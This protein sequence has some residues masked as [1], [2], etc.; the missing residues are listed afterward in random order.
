MP[1]GDILVF[2]TGQEEIESLTLL[3]QDKL[4]LLPPNASSLLVLALSLSHVGVSAL[5]RAS[6]GAAAGCVHASATQHAQGDSLDESRRIFRDHSRN[7]IRR[8]HG[9]GEAPCDAGGDGTRVAARGA[10]FQIA[11]VAA[12]GSCRSRERG[13]GSCIQLFARSAS[14]SS[15]KT[16]SCRFEKTPFPRSSAAISPASFFR[17]LHLSPLPQ[18]KTIGINDVLNFNYL[19]APSRDSLKRALQQ[20]LMLGAVDRRSVV[21]R[22]SHDTGRAD[23]AG[24][25][26]GDAPAGPCV[27]ATAHSE[28]G[29]PLH[30][31]GGRRRDVAP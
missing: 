3:L 2:L 1:P 13:K 28:Q 10:R 30:G 19:Q 22:T 4:K 11:R 24:T 7:Q 29:L 26:D 25:V 12:N 5:R 16:P 6:S 15:R 18:L 8:R 31:G 23:G 17:Y 27:R 21:S 9:N 14:A 20:L